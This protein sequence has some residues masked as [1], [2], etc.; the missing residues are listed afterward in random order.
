[1]ATGCDIALKS[2]AEG[3]KRRCEL[4]QKVV[5]SHNERPENNCTILTVKDGRRLHVILTMREETIYKLQRK[6]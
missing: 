4:R 6:E 2:T 1:M 5:M 3:R